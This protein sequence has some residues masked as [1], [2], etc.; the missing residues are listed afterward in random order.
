MFANC[1][2]WRINDCSV[3]IPGHADVLRQVYTEVLQRFDAQS[4]ARNM[5]QCN[6]ITLKELQSIQS[7]HKQPIKAAERLLNI[8]I[9]QSSTV[10]AFF[11]SAMKDTGHKAV[12]DTIVNGSYKGILYCVIE[13]FNSN[14][15]VDKIW[16][17]VMM[18]PQYDPNCDN[19]SI[20]HNRPKL[21]PY[22]II[23]GRLWR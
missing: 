4:V 11:M 7:K 8:V 16:I 9:D 18:K 20:E 5:F 12:Y 19:W 1:Y 23:I 14:D 13:L 15:I 3:D 22:I 10:Y 21:C 6:A 2:V 17:D